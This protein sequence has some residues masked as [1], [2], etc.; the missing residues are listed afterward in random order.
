MKNLL[1]SDCFGGFLTLVAEK[2]LNAAIKVERIDYH[3]N[4]QCLKMSKIVTVTPLCTPAKRR[5]CFISFCN[6]FHVQYS[7]KNLHPACVIRNW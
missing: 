2:S 7:K 4:F 5:L 1:L 6:S 3:I